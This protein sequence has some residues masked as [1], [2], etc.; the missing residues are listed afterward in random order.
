MR[1]RVEERDRGGERRDGRK[2]KEREGEKK[3]K[4]RGRKG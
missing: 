4:G 2:V 3:E 1:R